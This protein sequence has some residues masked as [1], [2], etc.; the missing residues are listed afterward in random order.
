[1]SI[2]ITV[3][4]DHPLILSGLKTLLQSSDAVEVI[5][6][7]TNGFDLM[8]GLK[9]QQPDVLLSDLHMP[10][11]LSG[12]HLIRTIR[13]Q[14]PDLPILILSAQ[15]ASAFNVEDI[16]AEGCSGYL[17]K[18]TTDTELLIKAITEVYYGNTFLEPALKDQLLQ[19]VFR[20][21]RQTGELKS[22]ISQR[23]VSIIKLLS[24]GCTS[25]EI[26]QKLYLSVRTVDSH[27][28]RIMQKLD[29]RNVAGLLKKAK[30]LNLLSD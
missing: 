4:D 16:M 23:Q 20:K 21:K 18:N 7:Y 12:L 30:E 25:Q 29:V 17:Y 5:A 3:T 19:S 9:T 22:I 27:R 24:E 28:H 15:E 6:T 10:G 14:Y 2:K 8:E 1:M 11:K 13:R 26:A